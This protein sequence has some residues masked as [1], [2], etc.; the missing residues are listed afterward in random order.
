[1]P[2]GDPLQ[3]ERIPQTK[4]FKVLRSYEYTW[5]RP[6]GVKKIVVPKGFVTDQ[7]SVP[8]W[9]LPF[10]VDNTGKIT[11]AAVPHDYGYVV[12]RKEGWS[13][14]AV[15]EMFRDAMLEAGMAKPRA[16][17]AWAGVRL[18]VKAAYYWNKGGK[19]EIRPVDPFPSDDV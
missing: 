2:F 1:M 7:A 14:A 9:V 4:N 6:E 10:I 15:D 16:Y 8:K 11:D 18:N 19:K 3:L 12:L 13:R 17:I 5:V